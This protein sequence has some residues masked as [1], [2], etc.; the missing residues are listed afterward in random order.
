MVVLVV[1]LQ[2]MGQG[3]DDGG[4]AGLGGHVEGLEGGSRADAVRV[5]TAG[6]VTS[7]HS[8]SVGRPTGPCPPARADTGRGKYG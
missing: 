6:G 7:A 2:G 3:V 8:S 1:Q 5:G 4:R